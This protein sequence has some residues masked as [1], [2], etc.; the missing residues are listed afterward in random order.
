MQIS[1]TPDGE[2][3]AKQLRKKVP[4]LGE[5]LRTEKGTAPFKAG[6]YL[7][8]GVPKGDVPSGISLPR[9]M[10]DVKRGQTADSDAQASRGINPDRVIRRT[11]NST[12]PEVEKE[13]RPPRIRWRRRQGE[14]LAHTAGQC[15]NQTGE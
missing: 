12:L 9:R 3:A 14:A 8:G 1:A 7:N 6:G 5:V 11:R 4:G 13:R 2:A 15:Y 10:W